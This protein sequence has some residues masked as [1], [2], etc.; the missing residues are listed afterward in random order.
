MLEQ[1]DAHPKTA[2]K[3]AVGKCWI[4]HEIAPHQLVVA[5]YPFPP[6][7]LSTQNK[8]TMLRPFICVHT[9]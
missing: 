5:F 7:F 3:V 9:Q 2:T 8:T 1:V 4:L 6:Q